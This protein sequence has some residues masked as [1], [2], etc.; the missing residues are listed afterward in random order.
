MK[1][2]RWFVESSILHLD[3]GVCVELQEPGGVGPGRAVLQHGRREVTGHQGEAPHRHH[4]GD[5]HLQPRD[6]SATTSL[7][8][9]SGIH[10]TVGSLWSSHF[11]HVITCIHVS[12]CSVTT[13]W[14]P[15]SISWWVLPTDL[16][17]VSFRQVSCLARH[18]WCSYHGNNL[19]VTFCAQ[20]SPLNQS[21]AIVAT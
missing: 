18:K 6:H 13:N 3:S 11:H 10:F 17:C 7:L 14:Y 5:H 21:S 2:R 8:F 9:L 20:L 1:L 12:S 19:I 15:L 4:H 16:L